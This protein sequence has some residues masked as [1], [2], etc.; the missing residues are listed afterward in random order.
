MANEYIVLDGNAIENLY[1]GGGASAWDQLLAGGRKIIFS[2]IIN[3]ELGG[4][5]NG[6]R[7]A[8][9]AW[10]V[11]N[12]IPVVQ[13]E[14]EGIRYPDGHERAGQLIR[15]GGDK[16]LRALMAQL[17]P[18]VAAL[19][20]VGIDTTGN[21]RLLTDD[22]GLLREIWLQ[23]SNFSDSELE[24]K[25]HS[26]EP[27]RGTAEFMAERFAVGD[28]TKADFRAWL[29]GFK[30]SE[31][32]LSEGINDGLGGKQ[33]KLQAQFD[34]LHG[35]PDLLESGIL[36]NLRDLRL[37]LLSD[38]AGSVSPDFALKGGVLV[39]A[40][41][42]L[43]KFGL[44][45]DVLSLSMV[46]S[47][48]DEL[49]TKA[50]EAEA[51]GNVVEAE[52]LVKQAN[53]L[54]TAYIFETAGGL[55][56]AA[57]GGYAALATL[58][59]LGSFWGPLLG[60][61]AGSVA[62]S[63][64][65]A[66]LGEFIYD[67]YPEIFDDFLNAA[68]DGFDGSA[69]L[70]DGLD[71]FG[72]APTLFE[73]MGF[74]DSASATSDE[75]NWLLASKWQHLRG[76]DGDDFLIGWKPEAVDA[77]EI[78]D[79]D[80]F[81]QAAAAWATYDALV[82]MGEAPEAP[83]LE[84]T[85]GVATHAM[86]MLL[87]GGAGD[88]WIIISGGERAKGDG[89]D[90]DDLVA[91]IGTNGAE[92]HGG[93]GD[94]TLIAGGQNSLLFGGD[95]EDRFFVGANTIIED[96]DTSDTVYYG[97]LR[98][99]GGAKQW[100]M[101]GNTAYWAPFS[102]VMSGFPVIGSQVL[103]AA[104]FFVDVATMKF[105]SYQ[106][107]ADG[108]MQMNVGWGQGGTAAIKDYHVDLDSGVASGGV[109]VF[110]HE[111]A[112]DASFE[113]L[114]RY[115]NLAL[116]SGFGIGLHGFDPLVLDLDGDGYELTTEA[117][118]SAFF[119][120]DG[121]GFAERTGWVRPDDGLL[122]LDSNAN[123]TID[124]ITEL[125]GNQTTSGFAMLA[126]HDAN[127][128]GAIDAGDAAY[129]QLRVWRDANQDGVAD[130]GEL[131]TLAELGIVSI[132]LANA[133]PAQST[134]VAGNTIARTGSFTRA[135][136]TTG[137]VADVAFTISETAT[138]WLGDSSVSASAAALP[139]LRGFGE[140][141]NLRVAMTMDAA[142]EVMVGDFVA[143][144]TNDLTMLSAAAEA[145]LYRW[146]GVDGV[147]AGA[148]GSA[149]F[150]ARKL[151]FLEKYS[152][153]E[154]M[155]RD[156]NGVV[157]TTNLTEMEELW[158]DQVQRLTLRLVVQ[159]PLADVFDGISYQT[160]SD[161]LVADTST[162]L[163]DLYADLLTDLP[164]DPAA[165]LAQWEAWTPLLGAMAEGMRR[166]DANL[167]RS[168]YIAAQLLRAMD[169]VS[170]PLDFV[171]LAGALGIGNLQV[172][173]SAADTLA[174]SGADGTAVYLTGGGNDAL[175]GGAGQDVY[176]FGRDIGTVTI[177]DEE[178]KPAGD[179]IRFAF[180][181]AGDVSLTRDGHDLLI[182]VLATSESV[183][184]VGQ[185]APVT[186]LSSD[187][188]L[189]SNKHV[190][191]IQFADGT[192]FEIPQIMSAVGT[193]TD[194]ND[195]MVG[196]MHS[197]V[198]I[199]G[200]GN[201][202]LE[203]GDDADL[204]V[205]HAGEGQDVV[206][207]VQ[208]T[209]LLRAAD[210]LLFG[211]DIAP[212]DLR[213]TRTGVDGD[214]LT[215]TIG[216]N[217]QSVLIEDQFA[218]SVLG[219]NDKLAPNS[220]IEAFGF[221]HFGDNW[222]N[223]QIQQQLIAAVTTN[224]AD[225]VLGFGDDDEFAFSAG[226]DTLVG[227]DGQDRYHW[228]Q[229]SGNDTIDEGARFIDVTV[230]LGGLSLTAKADTV[231]FAAGIAASDLV[232]SRLSSAPDLTITLSASGETLTVK[233]QFD[234]F[235]TGVLGAQWFDR[236]EWF[237]FADGARLSWQDVLLDVTTGSDG[238]DS[239]WG[240]LY[241]DTLTGGLGNDYL[242]GGGYADTY[243]FNAGDGQDV[244]DDNNQFILG[245]GF[246][247]IDTTPDVLRFGAGITSADISITNDAD[248]V[249]LA[250][251]SNG[252]QVTLHGQNDYYHTGV[253]GAISNSRIERIEFADGEV[254]TWQ[255][256]NRRAL[257]SATTSGDDVTVGFDLED[258]FEAS[259]GNDVLRGGDSGDTYVFGLG[260]GSDRIEESVGNANFDDN[261]RVEFAAAVSAQDVTFERNG[262]DLIVRIAG[263]T[264]V[265]TIAGQFNNYVGFT[266]NDVESF[267]FADGTVIT[268]AD[269][270]SQLTIGT[271]G[272]D[273][274]IGFHTDDTLSGGAGNDHLY[275]MDGADRYEFN[276][277]D[278][279][280]TIH[281]SVQFANIDDTDRV[282]FGAGILPS[283]VTLSRS[284]NA[285]TLSIDGTSDSI[286][287][288]GQFDFSS[289][290]SWNDVELFEFADGA[291]WTKRDV[292]NRL[293]GGTTGD[294]TLT[295]TFENDELNGGEGNDL[296][297]GGDGS[298]IYYFGRGHGQDT[299][300]ET[301]SNANLPDFDQIVMGE[302]V[303]AADLAFSR[304]GDALTIAIT[305]T[306]DN[307]TIAGQFDN[308][309]GFTN[310]D[311]EQIQFADGSFMT[312]ADIQNLLTVGTSASETIV[313]F[314]TDDYI[315]G[316]AGNDILHGLDGSDNY[317]F[318][319]GSGSDVVRE[320]VE[321]A[322]IDDADRIR[323]AADIAPSDVVWSRSGMNLVIGLVGSPDTITVE[324][325]LDNEGNTLFTWRD[326]EFFDFADGT[327]LA[328][329]EIRPQLLAST[330]GDDTIE[331]FHTSD[332]I[333]GGLGNDVVRGAEGSDSL[334]GGAGN[335][336]L[337]GGK[338]SDVI[339]GGTGDDS[340]SGD[341]G[342]DVFRFNLGDG[343]DVITEFSGDFGNGTG[344]YDVLEFGAGILPGNVTV[345]QANGGSDLIL[346][347][348]GTND[349]VTVRE[350]ITNSYHH[351]E[352]VRFADG[353]IWS[354]AELVARATGATPGN[355]TI[356]GSHGSEVLAGG[357]GND[358]LIGRYGND[359]L[360]GGPGNDT[361]HGDGDNDTYRFNL[362][363]GQDVIWEWSGDFWNGTGGHDTVEFGEGISPAD[364]I[365]TQYDGA[366]IRLQIAGT[367]DQVVIADAL[368]SEY[369]RNQVEQIRFADGTVWSRAEFV[370][371]SMT[372]TEGNDTFYGTHYSETI[373]GGAGNDGLVGRWGDDT[374][375]GGTGNDTLY[376]DGG[377]DTFRF[378]PG[379]GQDVIYEWSGNFWNGTGGHDT[380][381]FG[382]GILPSD[383]IVT[384][385]DGAHIRLQIAGTS[386][387]VVIADA[388]ASE[389][390][391]NQVEQVRFADGTV[392][393]RA[394]LVARSMTP[395]EGND[396]FYGSHYS[397]TIGGGGGNDTLVGRWGDDV[398]VG[399][400]GNDT[401]HGDGGN[402][403]FRFN[404]G[405]GQDTIFEWSG[406]FWNGTGGHDTLEFGAGIS[407]E[408][409]IVTTNQ[410]GDIFLRI[411]GTT[412]Q[413][414]LGDT[415]WSA[416][417]RNL[418]EQVRFA[419]GTVWNQADQLARTAVATSGN[420][421]LY[422]SSISDT[423]AASAGDD[424]IHAYGGNDRITG[425]AGNDLIHES[426]GDDTYVW[427]LGD[428][429][430]VIR[431]GG[432]S[433]GYNVIEFGPGITALDLTYSDG[434]SAGV[435]LV[436][437]VTGQ[438]GSIRIERQ[439]ADGERIDELR[440]ADGSVVTRDQFLAAASGQL[441][442]GGE[443]FS[444]TAA[445][446]ETMD[447]WGSD[448][449]S[450]TCG[451]SNESRI[452]SMPR[453][454]ASAPNSIEQL[455]TFAR[456]TSISL[457]LGQGNIRRLLST[458]EGLLTRVSALDPA[459]TTLDE[460]LVRVSLDQEGESS[461]P[462]PDA[463]IARRLMLMRQDL[464]AFGGSEMGNLRS[465]REISAPMDWYA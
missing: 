362:G 285:L 8:F 277:G 342:N 73:R 312:K 430:D 83:A 187:V 253:F 388:L 125:F 68:Y 400:T 274:I 216:T 42:L 79:A 20:N 283:Q 173:T 53:K 126:A 214:D 336:V 198:F 121:D 118:S 152:G 289:W 411:A 371:R 458:E 140:V 315:S 450:K 65:G 259:A 201:D 314:H 339:V 364:I 182:T 302:G 318:G 416:G 326:V 418:V 17:A 28:L 254:W 243:V 367:T 77:G 106:L 196:T 159:G 240:D 413:V 292:A 175:T 95:G 399:G 41:T 180:L 432:S 56:G 381:D 319:R 52:N 71:S 261:D 415:R 139:E 207:D 123:G 456:R 344:G 463:N 273:T 262:N 347:I 406:N 455:A 122:A 190:E 23:T 407:P 109:T 218:Y 97:G 221:K 26:V 228:G 376:G 165:A 55:A 90:G 419:D 306:T 428:G 47:I 325:G 223:K 1:H 359:I 160:G 235:Q 168:D 398:L 183:R 328:L 375:I 370:A 32:K 454:Y 61:V 308:Y 130:S 11:S 324:N 63:F 110:Q 59:G 352:Q 307:I 353:T 337:W 75:G 72:Y 242:S 281:E 102:T 237:E 327:T 438:P 331:G 213:F 128:D 420:D 192:I 321:F 464:A 39:G 391:R 338:G 30:A 414:A 340:L 169:G 166:A 98:I 351:L 156:A 135:D 148:I 410:W 67:Q 96:A 246:V 408:D 151:A 36:D 305:G 296:L 358:G 449:P 115:V 383:I 423:I 74:T 275:G 310:H 405:D 346:R 453:F 451:T 209:P 141:N 100:W 197:D 189:S 363:D 421:V 57:L 286:T 129:A 117:N 4:A 452:D 445:T 387:Q 425:G 131:A 155:P 248:N 222:S 293:M 154:L 462:G 429:D 313:G 14:I 195:Q 85:A 66:K 132:G 303:A 263:T 205:V 241:Q 185:F 46:L 276:L 138:R 440:F 317:F 194:G 404:R 134:A 112:E 424:V 111:W 316:G 104:A 18:A 433:D 299:I 204:Y 21:F 249:T 178:A 179:R 309:I 94:D 343:Q 442:G 403:T 349:Q 354:A 217:G 137:G 264:D 245:E 426:T 378:N 256:L 54:W 9:T 78:F 43:G 356:Y 136:G 265:L 255:E 29:D 444:G 82:A 76:G 224:G 402:D 103:T 88:D 345:S 108:Y 186:P 81:A 239:L 5:P 291:V 297:R 330:D 143:L 107:S 7:D 119:E 441:A 257:A 357:A 231:V 320:S 84:R 105:A 127:L 87:E 435:D 92:A 145:I 234:G 16:V 368:A 37:R 89:G 377:N 161:L 211:D 301:I 113:N 34:Q 58:R 181:S 38:T 91:L 284:G 86:S 448:G 287:V 397:E 162:A 457:E 6:L 226:N 446:F 238:A 361:L 270:M 225:T 2:S 322:N 232:F 329:D 434:G 60:A 465:M 379:D 295:G 69:P 439:L 114:H 167:V 116:K 51:S 384:Q 184:V 203:G 332:V 157:Q 443:M 215:I 266:N 394:E 252:D 153:Y 170:Q 206:R 436:I 334:D 199:G 422:G 49:R 25:G 44:V 171:A 193:G 279:Q 15:E 80:V 365:V 288:N 282:V 163:A 373:A 412:D 31:R 401:L 300:E 350:T 447:A 348:A 260:S 250:I 210:M 142:L 70:G 396:V 144:A 269:M 164:S 311:I 459:R 99:F 386:D 174:R 236:I 62:G 244:V 460:P 120:F 33:F 133:V 3:E 294:D 395:T 176:I 380:V 219:Y 233:N 149:G 27:Y 272:D 50:G 208:T 258:R 298:D 374:L 267:H 93:A 146:A 40:G 382:E 212:D 227:L 64:G 333:A 355:D 35:A 409:M 360:I 22:A 431:G 220:R 390:E 461:E 417:S 392:W 247:T 271:N 268:K 427:N 251:G 385:Y 389:N 341:E 191:D 19:Q 230:G 369:E 290:Y 188:L 147:A 124:G 393:N 323:F 280:D 45:G 12:A 24:A 158:A 150:D 10:R 200:L 278:G 101:E 335:D 304:N 229:G 202:T 437:G 172:G 372:P 13:F 48:A 366:H 177:T